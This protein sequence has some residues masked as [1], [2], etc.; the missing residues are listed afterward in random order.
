MDE[1]EK[2][3]KKEGFLRP[4]GSVKAGD[5]VPWLKLDFGLGNGH[6]MAIHAKF[7]GRM[8]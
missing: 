3:E 5:I 1:F 4:D 7:K 8:K 6:A 2:L